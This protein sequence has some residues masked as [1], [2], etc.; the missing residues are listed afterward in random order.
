M[1]TLSRRALTMLFV[2]SVARVTPAQEVLL[3]RVEPDAILS[4]SPEWRTNREAYDP[5]EADLRV[6]ASSPLAARLD[7]YFGSWCSDSRREVPR[8]LRILDRSAA[9]CRRGR[10]VRG[11][12]RGQPVLNETPSD[13]RTVGLRRL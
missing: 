6:I 2:L 5:A 11:R 3:G 13:S 10:P 1:S 9:A 7:V 12:I 4:I 8:L